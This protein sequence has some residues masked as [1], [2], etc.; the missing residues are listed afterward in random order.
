[1]NMIESGFLKDPSNLQNLSL[2]DAAKVEAF[3]NEMNAL[4]A[5][6]IQSKKLVI[7]IGTGG[8][9]SMK[10]ENGIRV[11]D[12]D[13]DA[14][15]DCA[16]PQLKQHF[17]VKGLDAFCVDS[18]QM[19]YS[20]VQDLVIA[21]CYMHENIKQPNIGF[22]VV[23]GTD[24][25]A[26]SSAAVSLMTGQGLPFSVVYT[27]AQKPIQDI[28]SDAATNL[29][30]A[31][32]TLEALN[33]HNMA[34]VLIVMGNRAV[35]ANGAVKVDDESANAFD[36]PLHRYI[37]KF[38][39]L[40]YPI[41]LSG[42]IVEK[43]NAPFKPEIWQGAYSHTLIVKSTLGLN[44]E[45]VMRQIGDESVQSVV[46][47]S[48]GATTSHSEVIDAVSKACAK[49]KIPAFVVNPVNGDANHSYYAS[50]H[51]MKEKGVTPL[52]MTLP[53][54]LAKI[55]I[56]LRKFKSDVNAISEFM[57]T[58]YVGEIPQYKPEDF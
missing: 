49:K 14:I 37:T 21:M 4:S 19:D 1:M 18:S 48:Y 10:T 6:E 25:M 55:E 5:E 43:R 56:A 7:A 58:N 44:P 13:F 17:I 8:T 20:Y 32:F 11:P 3:V 27:G 23:H 51:E 33:H 41:R 47:Y 57:A 36:S 2:L 30:N 42:E 50:G 28:M 45:M 24:T 38:N 22:L 40:R 52:L 46:L 53:S 34:E 16:D 31:L 29:R 35:R 26:Y 54:A 12:L 15:F 39:R 9:I